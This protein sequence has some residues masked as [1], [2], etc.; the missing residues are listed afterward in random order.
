MSFL[1]EIFIF[2]LNNFFNTV[3]RCTK[4]SR[5]LKPLK[6][7]HLFTPNL[8]FHLIAFSELYSPFSPDSHFYTS[9]NFEIVIKNV[10]RNWLSNLQLLVWTWRMSFLFIYHFCS[11]S[12][13]NVLSENMI[14]IRTW[15]VRFVRNDVACQRRF[16]IIPRLGDLIFLFPGKFKFVLGAN[17]FRDISE[18]SGDDKCLYDF[19]YLINGFIAW[20]VVERK[21]CQPFLKVVYCILIWTQCRYTYLCLFF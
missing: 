2:S 1:N 9:T 14:L 4:L 20:M 8:I 10:T 21:L 7:I 6:T 5:A 16:C 18:D 11:F 15:F 17:V 12:M 19:F 13:S 3:I